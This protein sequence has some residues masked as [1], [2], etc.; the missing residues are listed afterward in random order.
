M[1]HHHANLRNSARCISL[2]DFGAHPTNW[3]AST[4]RPTQWDR[5]HDGSIPNTLRKIR[6]SR[7]TDY[8]PSESPRVFRR[9]VCVSHALGAEDQIAFPMAWH[10]S[11]C[12]CGGSFADR[13][14]IGDLPQ[15]LALETLVARATHDPFASKVL[16]QFLFQG[17]P[18]LDEEAAI[19]RLV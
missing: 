2:S 12:N 4:C 7:K 6:H 19:D 15:A 13:Y 9:L 3:S 11:I 17:A 10:G 16:Q 5:A 1:P 18:C 14:H 8:Q